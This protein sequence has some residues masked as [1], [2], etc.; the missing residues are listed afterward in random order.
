MLHA[1]S[2][3][4]HRMLQRQLVQLRAL[5]HLLAA[6]V[7]IVAAVSLYHVDQGNDKVFPTP[8]GPLRNTLY[9]QVG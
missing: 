2:Y 7:L 6:P 1:M 4:V 3:L 9:R 5:L 8:L